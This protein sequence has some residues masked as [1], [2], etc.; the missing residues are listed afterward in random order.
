MDN[1]VQEAYRN[2]LKNKLY[3]LLC[4]YEKGNDWEKFLDSILIEFYG[5]PEE[6]RAINYYEL[7][8]KISQLRYLNYKYFRKMIFD[9]MSLLSRGEGHELL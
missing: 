4:E 1:I 7:V 3:G 8:A 9:C 5:F 6:F 2:K